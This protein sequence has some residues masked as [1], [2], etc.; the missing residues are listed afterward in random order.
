[1]EATLITSN[2]VDEQVLASINLP[3]KTRTYV[4]VS[5][6]DFI[7]N[8]KDI[9]GKML[10][11]HN[12]HSQ[13]YGIAR[14]GKQMFGTLTYKKDL[15]DTLET[16]KDI[17]LSIGIRNSYDKSMSLGICSGASV[18]VCENLMM[19]GEIV[20]MRTHRGRILDELKGLIFN[21]IS[22]AEDKFQTLYADSQSFKMRDCDNNTAFSTIGRLYGNGIL[23]ER[24]LPVVKKEWTNPS[25]D[26]FS[27]KTLW[28]L[29]NACTEA[30]KTT[31]PMLRMN[32]QIKLHDT[33]KSDFDIS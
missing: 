33:F 1:M 5:H 10:P 20:M 18:F 24:Q 13:K 23:K 12:L 29:Y 7:A 2:Q 14:E 4:P 28:R 6:S 22:N 8:V 3:E 16:T 31:P 19:N 9:A 17:G 30:L 15:D 32:N 27:D 11:R 21:A 26:A 25:H